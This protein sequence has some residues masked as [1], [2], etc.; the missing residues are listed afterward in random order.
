MWQLIRLGVSFVC[1]F[2]LLLKIIAIL[3]LPAL[4]FIN[5]FNLVVLWLF[6]FCPVYFGNSPLSKDDSGNRDFKI[7]FR[8]S[9]FVY[10]A[11]FVCLY[12]FLVWSTCTVS[13]IA[14][15]YGI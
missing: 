12:G 9:Y 3:L 7:A 15:E 6:I 8:N 4:M 13:D 14:G 1:G 11:L 10:H 5:P 2:P